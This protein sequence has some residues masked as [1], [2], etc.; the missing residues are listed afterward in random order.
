MPKRRSHDLL[1]DLRLADILAYLA[2]RRAGSVTGAARELNVTPSQVSKA[3]SRL[4]RQLSIRL[5]ARGARGVSLTEAGLRILPHLEE[6]TARL[7]LLAANDEEQPKRA[8]LTV[9]APSYLHALFL[10]RIAE[11]LP[12]LRLRG[13]ELAPALVRVYAAENLFDLTLTVR[14]ERLPA[15]WVSVPAGETRRSLFGSPRLVKQLGP[16]PIAVEALA[17]IPFISP[18]Y[19][20]NGQFVTVDDECPLAQHERT[21]GHEAQTI[22]LALEL[23]ARADQLVFGPAIAAQRYLELGV[24]AEVKVRGW[25]VSEPLYVACNGDRVL[26]PVQKAIVRTVRE[27]L[28][29]V[30]GESGG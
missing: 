12:D 6:I 15:G 30:Q 11:K 3:V 8:E 1:P 13:L 14:L 9:A 23:A 21:R 5:L 2:V 4:E 24:L 10:P 29:A 19:S 20:V 28:A 25:R 7:R 18:V 26:A 16:Q 17:G 22:G 27:T